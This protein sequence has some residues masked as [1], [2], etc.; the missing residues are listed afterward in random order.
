MVF[1]WGT[2]SLSTF[3]KPFN[4]LCLSKNEKIQSNIVTTKGESVEWIV[5]CF[6][7]DLQHYQLSK[8]IYGVYKVYVPRTEIKAKAKTGISSFCECDL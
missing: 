1:F 3:K 5:W 8:I 6:L 2:S 4:N 7:R